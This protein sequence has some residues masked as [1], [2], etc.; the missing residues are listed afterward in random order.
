MAEWGGI[1]FMGMY[2][3]IYLFFSLLHSRS[4]AFGDTAI[5]PAAELHLGLVSSAGK[6]SLLW[7]FLPYLGLSPIPEPV[8]QAPILLEPV[9]GVNGVLESRG[10]PH[11]ATCAQGKVQPGLLM[12]W[13]EKG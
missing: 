1:H 11:L 10:T 12:Q 13:L 2:G 8:S 5:H 6:I 7:Q 3:H 4:T 9:A